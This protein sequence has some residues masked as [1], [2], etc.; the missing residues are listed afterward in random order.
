MEIPVKFLVTV[1]RKLCQLGR[2]SRYLVTFAELSEQGK[3]DILYV[4]EHQGS[5]VTGLLRDAHHRLSMELMQTKKIF[6][7]DG[8]NF[9]KNPRCTA[10]S[11]HVE[12]STIDIHHWAAYLLCAHREKFFSAEY[13][14]AAAGYF[15]ARP[16]F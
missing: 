6:D 3:T 7:F 10:P 14:K 16:N 4:A 8:E 5:P 1:E 9:A 15:K 13:C 2:R 11:L 12:N